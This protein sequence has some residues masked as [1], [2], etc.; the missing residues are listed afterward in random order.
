MDANS[1]ILV[2]ELLARTDQNSADVQAL[3]QTM[4]ES[5][6]NAGMLPA[7]LAL[8]ELFAASYGKVHLEV[9][10][11]EVT[12]T[13]T[14]EGAKAIEVRAGSF[15]GCINALYTQHHAEILTQV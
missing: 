6:I 5:E 14:K 9:Q 11:D 15:A 12:M 10:G 13:V 3:A 4:G 8:V 1:W 2:G 7:I